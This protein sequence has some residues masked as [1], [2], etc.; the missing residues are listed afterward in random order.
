[1]RRFFF[2][3]DEKDGDIALLPAGES[4]HI[5]R[6]LRLSKGDAIEL[7][8]GRGGVYAAVLIETGKRVRARI[9][10]PAVRAAGGR[11]ELVVGQGLLKGSKMDTV[12]QKCTELGVRRLVP[13]FSRRSQGR[14]DETQSRKKQERYR[15]IVEA[16]CKQC[17][18]AEPMTV[19]P[20][21]DSLEFLMRHSEDPA[22]ARLLFWEEEKQMTLRDV[23]LDSTCGRA[24]I[25]LGPEGGLAE[26][27]VRC[28]RE[29]GWQIVSLGSLILRAETAT[30]TA[31]SIVQ[32]L[33]GNV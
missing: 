25:V 26:E 29:R 22:T 2:D 6:V 12:V 20:P 4:R 21:I 10:G 17:C 27:E 19:E 7:L 33:M 11:R 31:V 1:M 15:R 23:T 16:A 24:V 3:P 18:R 14:P 9:L 32:F 30:L 5:C 13:L 8:D 28:A